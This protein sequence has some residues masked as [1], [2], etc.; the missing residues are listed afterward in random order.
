MFLTLRVEHHIMSCHVI[1]RGILDQNW[2]FYGPCLHRR[3]PIPSI[4]LI[5]LWNALNWSEQALI[6]LVNL[7][8]HNNIYSI[9]NLV[10]FW[11][12]YNNSTDF[13]VTVLNV[14]F[15]LRFWNLKCFYSSS[16]P[17]Q[18][19]AYLMSRVVSIHSIH[20]PL[21]PLYPLWKLYLVQMWLMH[22][23]IWHQ[24]WIIVGIF[25]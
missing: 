24:I 15:V 6:W 21:Y 13:Q 2:P 18:R 17:V 12:M 14:N 10:F 9:C 8:H 22:T 4:C 16:K 25:S 20:C 1:K 23:N 3:G 7:I 11:R 5:C 19:A